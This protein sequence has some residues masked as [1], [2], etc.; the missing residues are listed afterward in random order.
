MDDAAP[1]T[2]HPWVPLETMLEVEGWM[3][4]HNRELQQAIGDKHTVGHG[5]CFTFLHGGDLY[6]H[7]NADGDVLLDLTP[8]ANWVTPI[9]STVTRVPPPRGQ[10][11]LIPDHM[12]MQLIM[13]LNSL[14]ASSRLVLRHEYKRPA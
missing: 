12:L 2:P 7:T 9:I 14:I 4:L 10:Y 11:W 8:E 5:V 3:D 6:L 1:M 13:G